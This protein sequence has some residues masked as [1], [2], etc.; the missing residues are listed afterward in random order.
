MYLLH[1][2]LKAGSSTGVVIVRT[3]YYELMDFIDVLLKLSLGKIRERGN[4]K[5][6]LFFF[7]VVCLISLALS[8]VLI[9]S[10]N[11][12]FF[13]FSE[14]FSVSL[15]P[16]FTSSL[17]KK[18]NSLTKRTEVKYKNKIKANVR[19]SQVYFS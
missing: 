7:L 10:F 2:Y 16:V 4:I 18:W 8:L 19:Y 17:R 3:Y 14:L 13:N 1:N 9:G 12:F 11:F 15:F 5:K 6:K